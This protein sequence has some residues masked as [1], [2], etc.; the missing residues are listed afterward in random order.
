MK[1]ASIEINC[2]LSNLSLAREWFRENTQSLINDEDLFER[3]NLALN[4]LLSNVITH[5]NHS[6]PEKKLT[7]YI[8]IT[9]A[10]LMLELT[11]SGKSFRQTSADLP[12]IKSMPEGGFGLFLISSAFDDVNYY[13]HSDGTQKIRLTR[14][15]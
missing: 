7:V 12:D 14:K 3:L 15:L 2:D 6:N 11:H 4:E 8:Q 9:A 13:S 1:T 5:A 10:I